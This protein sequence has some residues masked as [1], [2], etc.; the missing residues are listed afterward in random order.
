MSDV[1]VVIRLLLSLVLGGIV[2]YQREAVDR[3][4]GFRT[5]VL[6]CIGATLITLV[7]IDGFPGSDKARVAS[8]IV[9]GIGFLGAGTIIRQGSIVRGLTTAASI[10]AVAGIGIAV[11]AGFYIGAAFGTLLIY[12]VLSYGKKMEHEFI[13]R[14]VERGIIV[15]ALNQPGLFGKIDMIMANQ[16]IT[17]TGMELIEETSEEITARLALKLPPNTDADYIKAKVSEID[18]VTEVSWEG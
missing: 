17:M 7:S 8:Q 11:G 2:G 1:D 14:S 16:N 9:T 13:I 10:W 15:K 6:V 12:L 4:A 18:G 3:P 5:H